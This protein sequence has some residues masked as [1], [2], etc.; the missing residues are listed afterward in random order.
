MALGWLPEKV[1]L[2]TVSELASELRLS[3]L[4]LSMPAMLPVR[5]QPLTVAV[6][7]ARSFR[8]AAPNEAELPVRMLL[9]SV[10]VPAAS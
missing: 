10:T 3:M 6:P 2:R 7:P 1:L 8:I 9:L 4:P 5:V